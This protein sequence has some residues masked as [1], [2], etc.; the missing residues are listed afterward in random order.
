MA[1]TRLRK[2]SSRPPHELNRRSYQ[3]NGSQEP[4]SD[5][6]SDDPMEKDETEERLEK[7]IFGDDAGFL[8]ALKQHDDGQSRLV[9]RES[10]AASQPVDGEVQGLEDVPDA[11]VSTITLVP[12]RVLL[13]PVR[14]SSSSIPVLQ[15]FPLG[16]SYR[17]M[18][19]TTKK[20]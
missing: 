5:V 12:R 18:L 10:S 9:L 11:D 1:P 7:L 4:T 19:Q 3:I 17:R 8:S 20:K 2:P 14:S 16:L 13:T 6:D 15:L